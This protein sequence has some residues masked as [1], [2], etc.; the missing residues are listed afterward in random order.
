MRL[1]LEQFLCPE[2]EWAL[3]MFIA[4]LL[5]FPTQF[6]YVTVGALL[7]LLAVWAGEWWGRGLPKLHT[8]LAWPWAL[9][10]VMVLVGAWASAVPDVTLPKL[11]GIALGM[12]TLRAVLLGIHAPHHLWRGLGI[13][14]LAGVGLV[15]LGALGTPWGHKFP[16][17]VSIS[18]HIPR[19]FSELPGTIGGVNPNA[20]GG[21]TLFLLPLLVV[22]CIS[23]WRVGNVIAL[24]WPR[25]PAGTVW[26]WR[27]WDSALKGAVFV[28]TL[29]LFGMLVLSHLAPPGLPC[30]SPC[31]C[32]PPCAIVGHAGRCWSSCW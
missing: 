11:A 32:W 4:P 7:L 14:V 5:I 9:L 24:F 6:P 29:A 19:R 10:G 12:V 25:R 21:T 2:W 31:P 26:A 23:L 22:L 28:L 8:P 13:F 18:S 17:L 1:K 27:G 15:A 3:I 20:L 16:F 30:S